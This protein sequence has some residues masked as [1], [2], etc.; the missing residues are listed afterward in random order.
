MNT[1]KTEDVWSIEVPN[2]GYASAPTLTKTNNGELVAVYSGGSRHHV[3][4][5]GQLHMITSGDEGKSWTW[6]RVLADGMIDDRDAG[7]L[8]TGK[9]TLIVNWFTSLAWE[10]VMDNGSQVWHAGRPTTISD[11][12]EAEWQRRRARLTDEIRW[13]E[14]GTWS[15]RSTDGGVTWS[16]RIPTKVGSPHGPCELSDGRLLYVGKK[17]ATDMGDAQ[18]AVHAKQG[19][20]GGPYGPDMGASE[21]TDDGASWQLIADMPVMPGHI[22]R[23][24]HE[25]H[26]VQ[27]SN[28]DIIAHI[29]NQ[30]VNSH[31]YETLQTE[32]KD[33]GYTW[34]TPHPIGLWG[35]PAFLMQ[36]S[37]GRLITTIGHRREPNGNKIAIS[38]DN[39]QSWLPAMSINTD[40][41]RDFG[42]PS[43]VELEPNRF[44]TLWYDVQDRDLAFLRLARWS[45]V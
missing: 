28:G 6:P 34:S 23:D 38:E 43:T 18:K 37:D 9:G 2:L 16:P 19:S 10:W 33:G 29:R 30:N 39:G 41:A 26:A 8:Q 44:L 14:L 42:Y 17:A 15:I 32:S 45:L 5:F 27:A 35:Y 13:N 22:A 7:V 1:L 24:Y 3:C 31:L 11:E 36:T 25:L 40:S 20:I 4:P 12:E 21:S